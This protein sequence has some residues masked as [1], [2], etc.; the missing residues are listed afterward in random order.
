M[1]IPFQNSESVL[2]IFGCYSSNSRVCLG[3]A[4][5]NTF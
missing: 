5:Q 2:R 3:D 1:F 4:G